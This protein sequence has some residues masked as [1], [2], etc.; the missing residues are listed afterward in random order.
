MNVPFLDL[1]PQYRELE[2]QLD[3]ALDKNNQPRVQ[4]LIR[5]AI[6]DC[7]RHYP[8]LLVRLKQHTSVRAMAAGM[9]PERVLSAMNG[10]SLKNAYFWRLMARAANS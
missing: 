6:C 5:N 9:K 7:Q 4:E 10:P 3:A 8:D 2:E 1:K